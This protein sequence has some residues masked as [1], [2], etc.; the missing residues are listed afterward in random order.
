LNDSD[1]CGEAAIAVNFQRIEIGLE[2]KAG[3]NISPIDAENLTVSGYWGCVTPRA[4]FNPAVKAAT[5]RID[6][7]APK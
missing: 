2:R 4:I 7:N 5:M 1:H 3:S 6:K